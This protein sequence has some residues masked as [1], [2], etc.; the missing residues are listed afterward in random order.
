MKNF[1]ILFFLCLFVSGF[2]VYSETAHA[3]NF[4]NSLTQHWKLDEGV[5]GTTPVN[6][7]SISEPTVLGG[8]GPT[9][10]ADVPTTSFSNSYSAVFNGVD[11][12]I[13][14]N[15]SVTSSFSVAFWFKTATT[16]PSIG[17]FYEGLGMVDAEHVAAGDWGISWGNQKVAFGMNASGPD[18]T[19]FST[20]TQTLSQWHHVVGTWSSNT[21]IMSLYVDGVF[22]TSTLTTTD[23]RQVNEM[24]IGGTQTGT[25]FFPGQIDD[26]RIYD[27]VL[28]TSTI[29]AL[30]AGGPPPQPTSF[31]AVVSTTD[32]VNLSWT[33]PVSPSFSS[34]TMRR[35]TST[36]PVFTTDGTS[37]VSGSVS[38]TYSDTNLSDA[39]YYYSIFALDAGGNESDAV[40]STVIVDNTPPTLPGVPTSTSPTSSTLPLISWTAST[41]AGVGLSGVPYFL[42]WS[43]S[44]DFS[45]WDAQTSVTNSAVPYQELTEGSWYFRVHSID[46]NLN[47]T[48]FVTSSAIVIDRTAPTITILGSNSINIAEGQTYNDAG[49][50][51]SDNISGNLTSSIITTNNVN[52]LPGA[53][54]V[55]Y[56]VTDAAGNT[57]S[58]YRTVN[59]YVVGRGV[60]SILPTAQ[61]GDDGKPEDLNVIVNGVSTGTIKVKNPTLTLTFN[62]DNNVKGY[63]LSLNSDFIEANIS[64]YSKTVSFEFPHQSG[65][66]TL[67]AKF[68]SSTGNVSQ[69]IKRVIN[70]NFILPDSKLIVNSVLEKSYVFNHNLK[71]GS[72][73]KDVIEI[74]RWLNAHGFVIAQSGAGSPGKESSFYGSATVASVKKFQ[75]AH[76]SEILTPLGI[77]KG[78][79]LFLSATR[80]VVNGQ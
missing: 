64:P 22:N 31:S 3:L 52:N 78:T 28:T 9:Y 15:T 2:F 51:A 40:T 66:Y 4:G 18:I 30:A 37:L 29:V 25:H 53:Y 10:S 19:I 6:S 14:P 75:E 47:T 8:G 34:V 26:V 16:G 56:S 23:L 63:A 33:N 77:K 24:R 76:F 70:Y 21:G 71:F 68:Y 17:Q 62:G 48:A 7:G 36:F 46:G 58:T 61:F 69:V 79:G 80:A 54:T 38:T 74:Q 50:T 59:V 67:Y 43:T 11:Q 27:A 55:T 1:S 73:G 20:T 65:V 49:A 44:S 5:Q 41:D 35:S 32:D 12:Y 39:T 57:F 72:R 45:S 13:E 60:V 42:A